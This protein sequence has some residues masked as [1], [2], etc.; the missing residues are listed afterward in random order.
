MASSSSL[1]QNT[2]TVPSFGHA[3]QA[4]FH[5]AE[6]HTSPATRRHRTRQSCP[7]DRLPDF[8]N[9]FYRSFIF[10]WKFSFI[11]HVSKLTFFLT[12]WRLKF[13]DNIRHGFQAGGKRLGWGLTESS[14]CLWN[15]FG[16]ANSE[17]ARAKV[18]IAFTLNSR[19]FSGNLNLMTIVHG[20]TQLLRK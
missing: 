4:W 10:T 8:A 9:I 14:N 7:E 15:T 3:D 2:Q 17:M 19:G 16:S 13:L 18:K 1:T 20:F 11:L 12:M 6:N 5:E